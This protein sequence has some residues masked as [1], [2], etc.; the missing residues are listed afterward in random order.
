MADFI[1]AGADETALHG[2]LWLEKELQINP[3]AMKQMDVYEFKEIQLYRYHDGKKIDGLKLVYWRGE[4]ANQILSALQR[5]KQ[6]VISRFQELNYWISEYQEDINNPD[7]ISPLTLQLCKKSSEEYL[8]LIT[9]LS[10][11]YKKELET[12]EADLS[13]IVQKMKMMVQ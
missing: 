12:L 5:E 9:S 8:K 11:K 4:P 13:E 10:E 7:K 3:E 1:K 2:K 6:R